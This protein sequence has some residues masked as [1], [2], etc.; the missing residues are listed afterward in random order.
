MKTTL[1]RGRPVASVREDV[2]IWWAPIAT[3]VT[4]ALDVEGACRRT[5]CVS[6]LATW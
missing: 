4:E 5:L 1:Y 3:G 6:E 2:A